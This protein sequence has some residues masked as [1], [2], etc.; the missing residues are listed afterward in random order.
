ML[1]LLVRISAAA[2][3]ALIALVT[4]VYSAAADLDGL[5]D[6][7]YV[8]SVRFD[9]SRLSRDEIIKQLDDYVDAS[10]LNI[11]R[12]ASAPDD[13]LNKRVAFAFGSGEMPDKDIDW[14]SP[15]MSG[16]ITKSSNLGFTSLNGVYA[17]YGNDSQAASFQ[18]WAKNNL[19]A[20]AVVTEKAPVDLLSY[21]LL[22]VGAWVP[23]SAAILLLAATIMSWYV[24]RAHGRE[25]RILAG[26]RLSTVVLT[27]LRSLLGTLAIPASAAILIAILIVM[28]T[29]F[30]RPWFFISTLALY[31]AVVAA[32]AII[33]ALLMG[34]LTLPAV[35]DIAARRPA[36]RGAW[37][38]SEVLK[39]A[40]VVIVAAVVPTASGV[41]ANASA[42]TSQGATWESMG[43]SVTL[44]IANQLGDDENAAFAALTRDMVNRD[45]AM[46]SMSLSSNS[47]NIVDEAAGNDLKKLGFDSIVLTDERFLNTVNR[48]NG[49]V[50]GPSTDAASL[51][52][53]PDS[54]KGQLLPNLELW[55]TSRTLPAVHLYANLGEA[56]LVVSGGMVGTLDTNQRP[57]IISVDDVSQL[58]NHFLASAVSR[59]NVVFTDPERVEALVEERELDSEILSIDR[60]ADLGLYDAQTKQRNA[61]L[62]AAAIATAVLALVMCIS[63]TAWIFALLRRRRWFVQRTAGKS[64]N[65]ILLP[66]M[67]WE[68]SAAVL[69]GAVMAASF[70]AVAP[71]NIWISGFAP[72]TYL[73]L[74]WLIHQWSAT[75]TF[76][77]TLARRG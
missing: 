55:T 44:R 10:G 59:G 31:T 24:L 7:P 18:A 23:L 58:D 57:L 56:P 30:G 33:L 6:A 12:V 62:G 70:A 75:S 26:M 42:A 47:V 3:T 51:Q 8:A 49:A 34:L 29:G 61:Q 54:I 40:A 53:L 38:S 27:D 36:E 77:T 72:V 21:A 43:D 71:S 50:W 73:A 20:D 13:F 14:F 17:L 28:T 39:V 45:E 46:F 41:V 67:L 65:S 64:W 1:K 76:R 32:F 68:T 52:E 19:G 11:I 69:F 37:V 60:I 25:L 35:R 2:I 16:L 22:T 4:G 5:P 66:R 63:V 15:T 9:E 48:A 74:A